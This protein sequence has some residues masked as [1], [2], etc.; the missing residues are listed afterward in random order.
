MSILKSLVKDWLPP[1]MVRALRNL[2]GGGVRFKGNYATWQ[3]A[4][5]QCTGYAA[6]PILEKVLEATL[7][8]KRGEAAYE[9]DSV[10]LEK[11]EYSWPLLAGIMWAAAR[12]NGRLNVLDFGGALGST[13]FQNRVLLRTLPEV[14][15]NVVEQ[16]HYVEAGQANIHS[17][18]L[19]FHKSI[20]DCL[21]KNQ[22]NVILL[23]SVLQYLESPYEILTKLAHAGADCMIIDRTPF[24]DHSEDKIAIQ[25]V[26]PSIYAASYPMWIFSSQKLKN[27]L[28]VH[29]RMLASN[30][31]PEAHVCTS[32]N[33]KFQF[34]G[35]LLEN[36]R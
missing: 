24:S 36:R 5:A 2:H 33:F 27:L 12:N 8:V 21:T 1:A 11:I 31:S 3:E 16:A 19:K 25:D 6:A 7:K 35:L 14:S 22:P 29:W 20:D 10:L 34:Q 9:R 26:P 28:E 13:Y 18:E 23:S 32:D 30:L 15:W 4:A 17:V